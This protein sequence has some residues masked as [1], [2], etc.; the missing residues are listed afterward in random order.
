MGSEGEDLL[1]RRFAI[2]NVWRP[3]RGPLFDAPL[4]LCD[5]TSLATGDLV[6]QDLI[7]RDRR[8]GL[9][10]GYGTPICVGKQVG[11]GLRFG[12]RPSPAWTPVPTG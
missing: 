9:P 8:S 10:I 5:A 6:P 3:I 12:K 1:S 7:Y 4:A 11:R 2:I